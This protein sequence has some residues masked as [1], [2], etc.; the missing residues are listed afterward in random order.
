MIFY[1]TSRVKLLYKKLLQIQ[2]NVQ[3]REKLFH[4]KRKK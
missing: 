4:F 2:E 1:K 3:N